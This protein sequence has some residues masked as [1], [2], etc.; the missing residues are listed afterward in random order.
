MMKLRWLS[1]VGCQ[2]S[3]ACRK[4]ENPQTT[5][6]RE[7]T[8]ATLTLTLA[9]ARALLLVLATACAREPERVQQ[10]ASPRTRVTLNV[11]PSMTYAPLMIAKDEGFFAAEGI[12][13][14]L[15]SLESNAA[16]AA[17]VAGKIDVLSCGVRSGLFNMILRGTPMHVVA[18]KGHSR[19]GCAAEAFVAPAAMARRIADAGGELRG[20]RVA[21]VRGGVA[22]YLVARLLER[23]KLTLADVIAIPMPQGSPVSSRDRIEA[24]RYTGEPNL[25]ALI[26]EGA[27]SIVATTEEVEPGHQSAVLVYG[28]RLLR[29]DPLLGEKFMRAYLRGVRQ[30]NQGKSERNVAI[31]SRYTKLPAESI[32]ASCWVA[33]ADDGHVDPRAVQPFLDWA[34]ANQYLDAPIATATW[35]NPA[36]AD[37][38]SRSLSA[39]A[40]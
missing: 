3:A 24:V 6:N 4:R 28:K 7:P 26:A 8:T 12:D 33:I 38:A 9:L 11:N 20:E 22:E 32:R 17:L 19:P 40:Q 13:A 1:V 23:R 35:W 15:V 16:L 2:L 29:D 39:G 37:R 21:V 31:I 34:L 5:D 30:Y 14:E 10:A 36:F 27:T 18:D 25:S